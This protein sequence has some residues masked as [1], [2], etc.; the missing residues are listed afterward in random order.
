MLEAKDTNASV[1]K[2]KDLHKIFCGV[3]QYKTSSKIF[4]QAIYKIL[5]IQKQV[6]SSNR[7][8]DNF[9]GKELQNVSSRIPPLVD[10]YRK[11]AG[12]GP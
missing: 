10:S 9:R 7:G 5:T 11:S 8:Q 1:L 2:K 4:F 12:E 3:L 6:L